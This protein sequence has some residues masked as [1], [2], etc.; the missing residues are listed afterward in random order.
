MGP[1]L[2]EMKT[3]E[4]G[5]AGQ[6]PAPQTEFMV[7]A[8]QNDNK[9]S[10]E[11]TKLEGMEIFMEVPKNHINILRSKEVMEAVEEFLE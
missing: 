3:G 8:G 6:L 4:K 10:V 9:V 2:K 11:S 1:A 7:I 5:V